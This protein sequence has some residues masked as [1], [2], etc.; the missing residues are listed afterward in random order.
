MSSGRGG[1]VND[2]EAA[3]SDSKRFWST[4]S[5]TLKAVR[6]AMHNKV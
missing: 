1:Y 5:L 3:D 4:G 2:A 6:T